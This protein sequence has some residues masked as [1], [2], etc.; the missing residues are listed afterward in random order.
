MI[1]SFVSVPKKLVKMAFAWPKQQ[2]F[3]FC[4]AAIVLSFLVNIATARELY[5]DDLIPEAQKVQVMHLPN[6]IITFLHSSD[7]SSKSCSLRVV[8][9]RA[10]CGDEQFS[11]EERVDSIDKIEE[12]FSYCSE[13]AI[14]DVAPCAQLRT[15]CNFTHSDL[16]MPYTSYPCEIAVI[17]VGDFVH[18]EMRALIEKHFGSIVLSP[19]NDSRETSSS[20][21][22][23]L[24]DRISNVA[25]RVSYPNVPRLISTYR[26]L[27]E[28]WKFLLLQELFQQRMERCSRDLNETW[29]HPHPRFFYPVC[30]YAYVSEE[31]SENLLS[32]LLWQVETVSNTGFFEDEF[33]VAKNKLINQLQYLSFN[34]SVPSNA[35]LASYYADLFLLGSGCL[36]PQSFL[37]AS[38]DLVQEIQSEDL[39][40]CL[41]SFFLSSNRQIQV[42]QPH[43]RNIKMMTRDRI[44]ELISRVE[45]LSSFYRESEDFEDEED[46]FEVDDEYFLK[47]SGKKS[48]ETMD[49]VRLANNNKASFRLAASAPIV[50]SSSGSTEPF[51]QL[52]LSEKEKRYIKVIVSTMAEKNLI[53]LMFEKYTLEKKG[54]EITGVH[55]LRFIGYILSVPKLKDNLRIIRKSSFKWDAI[56]EGFSKRMKEELAHDNVYQYVPGFAK[57]TGSSTHHVNEYI[58]RKDFE[59][60]V[61]SLL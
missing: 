51:Y 15:E 37:E 61:R 7:I 54:K 18:Q 1:I 52:P 11:L 42:M 24:D 41:D 38:S 5:L 33:F 46:Q 55:P 43:R 56:I 30:G 26:D 2:F 16:P 32:F 17:A 3:R 39:F 45:A 47:G 34:A 6:G 29:I 36:C 14:R 59:G 40:Y 19:L 50:L 9:K 28:S 4:G 10:T 23:G 21:Q 35:F 44:E 8:F 60:L 20:I 12:F 13:R 58:D 31:F 27:K 25:V 53:Q 48:S 22:I 57:E 49:V